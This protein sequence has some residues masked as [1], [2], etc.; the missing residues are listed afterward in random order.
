MTTT[1]STGQDLDLLI[2]ESGPELIFRV[3][4]P[5]AQGEAASSSMPV[6]PWLNGPSGRPLAGALGV[7]V[8]NVLGHAIML[9]RPRGVW[10]VSAEI[11][12]DLCGPVC[13]GTPV[14]MAEGHSDHC[15][16]AGGIASGSV[17]DGSGRL[18]AL[19]RQQGRWVPLRR[20]AAPAGA[21]AASTGAV[22]SVAVPEDLTGV[23]GAPSA[24][25]DGSAHLDLA[26][27][28]DLANP[29]GN[30][31][32]GITLCACDLVAQASLAAVAGPL[33]TTS[34]HVA[35][36]R[37]V[38][39]GTAVRFAGRVLH[40]GLTF[41]VTQVTASNESGKPSVIATVTTGAPG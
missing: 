26:V 23:L 21:T 28:R 18:I 12:V 11:S 20:G 32:G 17:T 27:T 39:A 8:D 24:A 16:A 13:D 2:P 35:Y 36:T 14:L 31:H 5:V 34:I 15:D 33:S 29:L 9:R 25:A 6:G 1:E 10:S 40:R 7:L 22:G 3:A 30:L 19:C 4:R 41:A 38:P 37:P